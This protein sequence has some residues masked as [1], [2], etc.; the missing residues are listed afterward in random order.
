MVWRWSFFAAS[1]LVSLG[2]LLT[3]IIAGSVLYFFF[4]YLIPYPL[5]ATP[6]Y[7]PEFVMNYLGLGTNDGLF[8]FV[9]EAADSVWFLVMFAGALFAVGTLRMVVEVGKA[10]GNRVSGGAA[11]PALIGSG[12]VAAI[13]G[14]A[15]S[16]V[17]LTG[18]LTIPM[19]K[20]RAIAPRWPARLRRRP[21]R[22]DRSCR[23]YLDSRL[24]SSLHSSTSPTSRW[25]LRRLFPAY[26]I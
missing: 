21:A 14:T 4:G 9:R 19:M 6:Q 3:V 11:F 5:L 7:D 22:P 23:Q 8:W 16:N 2:R 1:E 20:A 26:C 18:R 24:S 17:V 12:I 15:V 13:M 10:A 25:H